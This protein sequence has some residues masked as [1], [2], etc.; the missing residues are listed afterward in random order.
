MGT[1]RVVEL[2]GLHRSVAS[3]A[4]IK[5]FS[6][7][8]LILCTIQGALAL[9]PIVAQQAS[10]CL[11]SGQAFVLRDWL[12]P[13][14][15][16]AAVA[17]APSLRSFETQGAAGGAVDL[18]SRSCACVD[19]LSPSVPLPSGL[20]AVVSRVDALRRTLCECTERPLLEA[21][22]LQLLRYSAGGHYA[23]HVDE[24][25]GVAARAVRRSVSIVAFL[26]PDDWRDE[27][28][29]ALRIYGQP[30]HGQPQAE[31]E[32]AANGA[33]QGAALLADEGPGEG[34]P[35]HAQSVAACSS[36]SAASRDV[37]PARGTLVLFDACTLPH[38]VLPTRR[39]RL[40]IVGWLLEARDDAEQSATDMATS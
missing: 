2:D 21:A 6:R 30:Q 24:G 25:L 15:V 4:C 32:R 14:V 12:P 37:L 31:A 33:A 13:E 7:S 17:D 16:R 23:R 35:Q 28:G 18:G 34:A 40:A 5:A 27:D 19:L 20:A 29:G 38:E 22:E 9:H 36:A 26:T 8:F 1:R 10:A 39:E 11:A 3:K